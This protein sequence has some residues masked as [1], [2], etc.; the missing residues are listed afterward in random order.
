MKTDLSK[1]KVGDSIWTIQEGWAE[2]INISN[3][4]YPIETKSK[5]Y[6]LNGK[7]LNTN[8]HPS[9]FLTNPF[10]DEEF[11]KEAYNDACPKCQSKL[12]E[13]FPEVFKSELEVGKWYKWTDNYYKTDVMFITKVE[14][15]RVYYYGIFNENWVDEYWADSQH[16]YVLATESEVK[17]ALIN[18]LWKKFKI[19]DAI[20]CVNGLSC[21]IKGDI[22]YYD[23]NKNI[24]RLGDDKITLELFNNGTWAEIIPTVT[25]L[26]LE[27]RIENLEN[28]LKK[29]KK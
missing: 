15:N 17:E 12:K 20:K 4:S 8:E 5:S 11:I 28:E 29:I 19:G 23:F 13:K 6:G 2:V 18:E 10:V 24:L 1:V 14:E 9:A 7:Y 26:T 3:L 21:E 22:I 16:Q 25:E 27:Q